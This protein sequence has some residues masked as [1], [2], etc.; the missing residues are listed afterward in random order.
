MN[1]VKRVLIHMRWPLQS[2]TLLGFLFGMIVGRVNLSLHVI[3]GFIA[4]FFLCTGIAVFN[5]Y[6]DKD[7]SPVAGLGNPPATTH[8]MLVGAW[9]LKFIGLV[10]AIFL[11]R[12]FLVIYLV[13]VILSVVYSHEKFRFKSS[14]Y[15]AV[16]FNFFLGVMTFIVADS[17]VHTK[18]F[19]VFLGSMTAGFFL[20]SIY[21]MTQIHQRKEDEARGDLSIAVLYGKKIALSG[22]IILMLIAAILFSITFIVS[23][24]SWFS[25]VILAMYFAMIVYFSY[26][27]LQKHEQSWSDFTT[28]NKLVLRSSYGA[29]II[30]I[31]MYILEIARKQ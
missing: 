25:L 22:V 24:Q 1:E 2:F 18:A 19:I 5:S 4:W 3:A 20:A 10:I 8:A 7:K 27:W 15:I 29:N 9:L 13:G 14:G 30:L 12:L 26:V 23:N 21:L 28:M 16:I 17:F 6:Y 11:H 31:I